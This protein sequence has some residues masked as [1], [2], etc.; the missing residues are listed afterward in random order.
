MTKIGKHIDYAAFEKLYFEYYSYLCQGMYRF[1]KDE[2]ITKDIVQD[3]F[4]KYWQKIYEIR[5]TESPKAYLI[6]HA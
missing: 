6:K 2:E 4:L 3:V 5:I 1:V